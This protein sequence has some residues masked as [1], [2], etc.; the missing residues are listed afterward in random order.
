MANEEL[1]RWKKGTHRYFDR[2]WNG[3]DAT[4]TRADAYAALATKLGTSAD[5]CHIGMFDVAQCKAAIEA[6]K[7][8]F[9]T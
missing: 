4:F 8:L 2:L 5:Q 1:R 9:R 6:A 7:A 3:P